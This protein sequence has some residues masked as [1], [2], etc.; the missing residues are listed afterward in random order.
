MQSASLWSPPWSGSWSLLRKFPQAKL[1]V[2]ITAMNTAIPA[3]IPGRRC[4]A[5]SSVHRHVGPL[6]HIAP[7]DDVVLHLR[8]EL[9]GRARD[10]VIA[11]RLDALLHVGRGQNGDDLVVQLA[12][13]PRIHPGR[14]EQARPV[15]DLEA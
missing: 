5:A 11:Q 3:V 15:A 4:R 9:A 1:T 12:H 14:A 6:D 2:H 8:T 10:H 13:D 7:A